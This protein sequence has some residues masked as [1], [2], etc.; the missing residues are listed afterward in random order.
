M[1][2]I[3]AL[4]SAA[5]YG[6]GDFLGG[7]S[8]RKNPTSVTV[9]W[10]QAA[11]LITVLI[12]APLLSARAVAAPDILWG[13]AG[14]ISGAIG[15]LILFHGL[16][17]AIVSIVSPLSALMGA[18]FPVFF[19]L[20]IGERP[21]LLTWAGVALSLPAI[22]FLS[23]ERGDKVA[24][25]SRSVRLGIMSGL[26]FG[27]FFIL[28]SRTSDGSGLWPLAAARATT[29]PLFL[30]ISIAR[31][32]KI[33]LQPGTRRVTFL[34]GATDMA[35]NVFYLLAARTGYLIIA[36]VL[37]ALYPAPT[38]ILQKIFLHEKLTPTRIIGLILSIA[39]AAL[40]S[41]GG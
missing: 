37:T 32:S 36:V 38:V 20:L 22:M 17:S 26:F 9:A 34:S 30:L 10:S 5:S 27:G 8:S 16:S 6:A 3:Y 2:I 7:F 35:A 19:G 31:K 4:L 12:A 13:M 23:W 24:H 18:A 41:V 11:G 25:V 28:I 29:V 15:V 1:V 40:I 39:G 14:G 21:S 33:R